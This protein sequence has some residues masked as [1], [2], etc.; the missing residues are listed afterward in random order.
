MPT[1]L[2]TAR[3]TSGKTITRRLNADTA[4]TVIDALQ[5]ENLTVIRIKEQKE[6]QFLKKLRTAQPVSLKVLTIFSRQF[7]L[8]VSAGLT[9]ARALST[10]EEQAEFPHFKDILVDLR[11]KIQAGETLHNSMVSLDCLLLTLVVSQ[12][13]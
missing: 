12:H 8:L 3:D 9:L 1:Y 5:A 6:S 13:C 10:L 4:Q 2:F 11:K 7:A